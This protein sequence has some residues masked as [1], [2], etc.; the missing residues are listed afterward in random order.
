MERLDEEY[1]QSKKQLP[2]EAKKEKYCRDVLVAFLVCSPGTLFCIMELVKLPE[3]CCVLYRDGIHGA[4]S[5]GSK[6]IVHLTANTKYRKSAS[7]VTSSPVVTHYILSP[8]EL[9]ASTIEGISGC[10]IFASD[11]LA[12]N[13]N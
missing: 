4:C 5:N 7:T 9:P 11:Y 12:L 10:R 8:E 3:G 2:P 6:L 1:M 13:W